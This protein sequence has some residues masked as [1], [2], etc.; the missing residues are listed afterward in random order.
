MRQ[1]K[2]KKKK[3][4]KKTNTRADFLDIF[5]QSR[6]TDRKINIYTKQF[7]NSLV[8][9][10]FVYQERVNNLIAIKLYILTIQKMAI[11]LYGKYND[12]F[13]IIKKTNFL[14]HYY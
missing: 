7:L 12:Y 11:K 4:D 5:L 2:K 14:K 6:Y 9:A 8:Y 1:S 3:I 10:L 13:I